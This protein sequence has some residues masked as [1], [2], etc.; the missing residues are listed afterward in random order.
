MDEDDIGDA[1]SPVTGLIRRLH[2]HHTGRAAP[3][4]THQTPR[5]QTT[6]HRF[7][8]PYAPSFSFPHH[9]VDPRSWAAG[10]GEK[11]SLRF[12]RWS[13]LRR[14][15]I[16][17]ELTPLVPL[18]GIPGRRWAAPPL[19]PDK[20]D[21]DTLERLIRYLESSPMILAWMAIY[22]RS[23]RRKV[24]YSR[25]VRDHERWEVLL[26]LR[27]GHVSQALPDSGAR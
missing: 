5:D 14:S 2:R 25:R 27:S 19:S 1:T 12:Y 7:C 10:S 26:A 6:A 16:M 15:R 9:R 4:S 8:R 3:A 21:P 22:R 11:G 24:Q 18:A 13:V 20:Y 23:H 17:T